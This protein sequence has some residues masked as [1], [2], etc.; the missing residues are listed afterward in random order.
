MKN[1]LIILFLTV[2]SFTSVVA[3]DIVDTS[4]IDE[5][6]KEEIKELD[7]DFNLKSFESCESLENVMGKYIKGYWENNKDKWK[8]PMYRMLDTPMESVDF[9]MDERV[10]VSESSSL[11][12]TWWWTGDFSETNVQVGWVDE[13]DIVKTDWKYIY[14][15]NESD[16]HVYI[17]ESEDLKLVKKIKLPSN[18]YSPVLYIWK[19]RL[20]IIA[21]GYSNTNYSKWGYWINR[22]SKT[23]TIVFDTTNIKNPVLSKLYV[24]DWDLR[25][26]RNDFWLRRDCYSITERKM[27]RETTKRKKWR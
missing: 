12:K 21:S 15:Y 8:Y 3:E 22:N 6:E 13:S 16:K 24:A 18:F 7:F 23:Y 4:I 5:L 20:T 19:D 1:I 10:T 9:A 11:P 2:F 25:K 26:S 27:I 17:V 14:Y